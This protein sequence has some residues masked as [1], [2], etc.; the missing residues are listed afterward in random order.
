MDL[1]SFEKVNNCT[2][3]LIKQFEISIYNSERKFN[4]FIEI[5]FNLCL[6]FE[7]TTFLNARISFRLNCFLNGWE[8]LQIIITEQRCLSTCICTAKETS[9]SS[10]AQLLCKFRT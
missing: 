1:P 4:F 3:L 8:G 7:I 5:I 10:W 6:Y 2:E 9:T